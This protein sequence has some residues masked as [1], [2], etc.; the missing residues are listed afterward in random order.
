[1]QHTVPS[2]ADNSSMPRSK[3]VNA[4]PREPSVSDSAEEADD[5]SSYVSNK[6]ARR[7]EENKIK[8]ARKASIAWK[9]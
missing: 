8:E 5:V 6:S 1:M 9:H 3:F 7:R 4:S 2:E